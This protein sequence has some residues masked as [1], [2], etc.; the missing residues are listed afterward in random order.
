VGDCK[1]IATHP[2]EITG[3]LGGRHQKRLTITGQDE[4]NTPS[5]AG[6]VAGARI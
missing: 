6:A 5:A 3:E 2:D 1:W 4:G